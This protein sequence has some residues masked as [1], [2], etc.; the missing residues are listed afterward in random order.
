MS[1]ALAIARA[2]SR[3]MLIALA[4]VRVAGAATFHAVPEVSVR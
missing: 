2:G 1:L 3:H 4:T